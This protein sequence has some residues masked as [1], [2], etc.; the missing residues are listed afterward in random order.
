MRDRVFIFFCGGMFE[1]TTIEPS[2]EGFCFFSHG[3]HYGDVAFENWAD[4]ESFLEFVAN[5]TGL[6]PIYQTP[7]SLMRLASMWESA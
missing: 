6:D 2:I 3:I 5:R 4:G 1:H 7:A